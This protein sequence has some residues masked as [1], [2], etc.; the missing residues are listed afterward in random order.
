MKKIISIALIAIALMIVCVSC[1]PTAKYPKEIT[2]LEEYKA[3]YNYF[4]DKEAY[5]VSYSIE[6]GFEIDSDEWEPL[7]DEELEEGFAVFK[8]LGAMT[9]VDEGILRADIYFIGAMHQFQCTADKLEK[10]KKLAMENPCTMP[11]FE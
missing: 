8:A 7:T 9:W 11:S 6:D 5:T 3:A 2:T 1:E 4:K 10:A